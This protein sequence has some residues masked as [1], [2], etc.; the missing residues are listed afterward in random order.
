MK[1]KDTRKIIR[2]AVEYMIAREETL[3]GTTIKTQASKLRWTMT[4]NLHPT[5]EFEMYLP[6]DNTIGG[7]ILHLCAVIG[8]QGTSGFAPWG[9]LVKRTATRL[10]R[11]SPF[12]RGMLLGQEDVVVDRLILSSGEKQLMAAGHLIGTRNKA[13]SK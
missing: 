9:S 2:H 5:T 4:D 13:T 12:Y 1:D 7:N 6:T 11:E 8:I 3:S 10:Q